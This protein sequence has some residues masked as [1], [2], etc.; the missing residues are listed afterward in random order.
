MA[1]PDA[2]ES[3]HMSDRPWMARLRVVLTCACVVGWA[4]AFV[5]SHIP[6][7]RLPGIPTSDKTLHF[8]GYAGLTT[9]FWLAL[10]SHG[11]PA[12]RRVLWCLAVLPVYGVFDELTQELVGRYASVIDWAFN[13]IGTVAATALLEGAARIRALRASR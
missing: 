2:G 4:A 11:R 7:E 8:F 6:I 10:W 9:L 12:K 5:A 1:R 3:A 13:V